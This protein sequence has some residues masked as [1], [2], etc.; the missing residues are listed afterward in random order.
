MKFS[1]K[2]GSGPMKKWLHF[3]G[4][5]DTGVCLGRGMHCPNAS[6]FSLD[7]FVPVFAFAVLGLVSSVLCQE[8]GW[9]E[10]LRNDLFCVK[11]D[12]K[13]SVNQ[14]WHTTAKAGFFFVP[15]S[16]LM[17][18]SQ[19]DV[20]INVLCIVVVSRTPLFTFSLLFIVIISSNHDVCCCSPL[21]AIHPYIKKKLALLPLKLQT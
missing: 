13:L 11:W 15:L 20:Y 14:L 18:L 17:F 2:V 12:V 6:I 5:P 19:H 3:G 10:C 9:E 1:G 8:L 21:N 16:V 4:D 7:Y